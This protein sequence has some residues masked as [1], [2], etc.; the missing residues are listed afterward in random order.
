M[1]RPMTYRPAPFPAPMGARLIEALDA[2][3]HVEPFGPADVR[4]V[5]R[6][7]VQVVQGLGLEPMIVRGGVDVGGAE[8]DHVFVVIED[9]VVDVAL[10]VRSERFAGAV[11]AWV[12]GDLELAELTDR[13]AGYGLEHRVVGE[14]P[15][16]LRYRGAPLWGTAA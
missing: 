16:A 10:P 4:G 12:A 11:R 9:R 6:R 15:A 8:L 14:Y 5:A 13:A 1:P 3:H 2:A 7:V